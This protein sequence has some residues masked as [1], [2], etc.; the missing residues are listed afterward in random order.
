MRGA[1]SLSI[2]DISIDWLLLSPE[3]NSNYE[4]DSDDYY[5]NDRDN[6]ESGE[7]SILPLHKV[8]ALMGLST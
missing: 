7:S 5:N 1:D 8:L 3:D 2:D 6:D 4:N